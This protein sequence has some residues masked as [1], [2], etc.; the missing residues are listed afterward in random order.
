MDYLG[1]LSKVSAK[2]LFP[3]F[4]VPFFFLNWKI[5]N[6]KNVLRIFHA[7]SMFEYC[8][9]VLR[10]HNFVPLM[11]QSGGCCNRKEFDC[12]NHHTHLNWR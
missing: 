3:I 5:M 7:H 1:A 10:I 4:F 6:S 12:F 9:R 2:Q 11:I 8:P